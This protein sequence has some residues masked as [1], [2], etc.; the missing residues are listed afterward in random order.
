MRRALQHAHRLE[1][2]PGLAFER[3]ADVNLSTGALPDEKKHDHL[4]VLVESVIPGV[5]REAFDRWCRV[6]TLNAWTVEVVTRSRLLI[7]V[8][9]PSPLENGLTLHHTYGVPYIPGTAL[10]GILNHWLAQRLG[11]RQRRNE[12]KGVSYEG[13]KAVG[14]PGP[15]HGFVFGWPEIDETQP[16]A[17]G[18]V[19][20]DDAWILP[21]SEP[22]LASDVVTPH[23][24]SYYRSAGDELPTDW[25]PP[26]PHPFASIRPG[27]A[28]LLAV[29]G[30]GLWPRL[31]L[32]H[33]LDALDEQG[34][35]ART[36]AGYGRLGCRGAIREPENL[37]ADQK[38]LFRRV[39]EEE[40]RGVEEARA[41][42]ER[43]IEE[44]RIAA[45]AE[46]IKRQQEEALQGIRVRIQNLQPGNAAQ[47]VPRI[48]SVIPDGARQEVAQQIIRKLGRTWIRSRSEKDW[49]RELLEIADEG[50]T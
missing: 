30:P 48:L 2:H 13:G 25:D 8:G 42:R 22:S 7:G 11:D 33:L 15:D 34:I 9:N 4:N 32:R 18:R 6:I 1:A 5:Y 27:A 20:F 35:G 14:L 50:L 43:V 28:F 19:V 41:R 16:G 29:S 31:A 44:Q 23:Q 17:R 3:Y 12:W 26:Q 47:E 38:E 10:K 39:Q 37:D 24:F 40:A 49:V 46:E 36:T 45:E 21:S